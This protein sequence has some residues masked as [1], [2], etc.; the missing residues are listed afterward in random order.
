MFTGGYGSVVDCHSEIGDITDIRR[1]DIH[2]KCIIA[3]VNKSFLITNFI[4][5]KAVSSQQHE[6]PKGRALVPLAQTLRLS[7]NKY[8]I[9]TLR[10]RSGEC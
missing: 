9:S 7:N 6:G 8:R 1:G 2:V 5:D 10:F 4:R 3:I